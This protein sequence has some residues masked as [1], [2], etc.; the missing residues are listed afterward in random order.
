M[1]T[2]E[3]IPTVTYNGVEYSADIDAQVGEYLSRFVIAERRAFAVSLI[4]HYVAGEPRPNI[5]A[6][7][8]IATAKGKVPGDAIVKRVEGM[9]KRARIVP[10]VIKDQAV[11]QARRV[12]VDAVS[13][14]PRVAALVASGLFTHE[15]AVAMIP[16]VAPVDPRVVTLTTALGISEAQAVEMLAS[17]KADN[18]HPDTAPNMVAIAPQ[19][20]PRSAAQ[21]AND[22]RLRQQAIA[23][24]AQRRVAQG[25]GQ[26]AAERVAVEAG[27][28]AAAPTTAVTTA[29]KASGKRTVAK[30]SSLG[31]LGELLAAN[32]S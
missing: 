7:L 15:Q 14:D 20:K 1:S 12:S 17:L 22:E 24:N 9:F 27:L 28:S 30:V 25:N 3:T 8:M 13:D 21:L 26:S 16:S 32:P 31:A 2:V 6:E 4:R 10:E 19:R 5:P 23:R 29:K 18:M 11:K